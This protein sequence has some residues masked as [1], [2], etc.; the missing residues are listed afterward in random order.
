[1]SDV[2]SAWVDLRFER[3]RQ[4]PFYVGDT[5]ARKAIR[6]FLR[7]HLK[8]ANAANDLDLLWDGDRLRAGLFHTFQSA[9]WHGAPAQLVVAEVAV[10]DPEATTWLLSQFKR[11]ADAFG[12]DVELDVIGYQPRLWDG[13][14]ALGFGVEAVTLVGQPAVALERLLAACNPSQD[15]GPGLRL[16]PVHTQ[17]QVDAIVALRKRIFS[18]APQYCWFGSNPSYLAGEHVGLLKRLETQDRLSKVLLNTQDQVV[19]YFATDVED[20]PH[21]GRSSGMDLLIAP[22]YQGRGLI[23]VAYRVLLEALVEVGSRVFKGGTSQPAVLSL[24]QLMGRQ[25]HE[26]TFRKN[27]HFSRAHFAAWVQGIG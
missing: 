17:N 12:R 10:G 25:L 18:A 5:S 2:L 13:L 19:G 15:P 27:T 6:H 9:G 21:W 22:E 1:M 23:K 11:R 24:G 8:N 4:A 7:G 20:S 14:L 26:V 3:L 16:E